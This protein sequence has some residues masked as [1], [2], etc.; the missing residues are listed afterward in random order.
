MK[1]NLRLLSIVLFL[2]ATSCA[3]SPDGVQVDSPLDAASTQL[4]TPGPNAEQALAPTASHLPPQKGAF[5]SA[6][7]ASN[8]RSGPGTEFEVIGQL[9]PGQVYTVMG[10]D[11]DWLQLRFD[12]RP[13]WV[14]STL[15]TL[16]GDPGSIPDL[17]LSPAPSS[18]TTMTLADQDAAAKHIRSF[19]GKTDLTLAFVGLTLMINSPNADRQVALFEDQLGTRY[20]VDPSTYVIAQIEPSGVRFASGSP[21]SLDVIRQMAHDLAASSPGFS[22]LEPTLKYEEGQKDDLHFFVWIDTK[23]GW[24]FNRPQLQVGIMDDGSLLTYMNT[25]IWAP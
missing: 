10:K 17:T 5:V 15:V 14:F 2:I 9:I 21:V 19:L 11:H 8:V 18:Q 25:L 23:P 13:A 7:E 22:N 24:K 20:S 12:D 16:G 4:P 1:F 6:S 3:S